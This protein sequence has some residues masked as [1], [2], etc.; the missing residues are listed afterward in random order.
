MAESKLKTQALNTGLV[1][2]SPTITTSILPTT[3]DGA[4][5][6]DL[7]HQF[8][9]LFLAEGGVINFD[10]GDATITQVGNVVTL[11]GADLVTDT[12]TVNT[13]LMPDA[14]DGA[15]LGQ[16]G[17]AFSDLFLAE[18]GIINWDSGDATLT[19]TGNT[20]ALGS[21][22]FNAS[23]VQFGYTTTTTAAGTLT[24][25]AASNRWQ[26]FTGSTTHTVTL[27]D[28]T[29]L[30]LGHQYEL[31]N[32][33][34]GSITVNSSGGNNVVTLAPSTSVVLTCILVT[35]TTAASW[36][37]IYKHFLPTN[38]T[39]LTTYGTT[40][41]GDIANFGAY[42][43]SW[44]PTFTNLTIGS[45]T[46]VSRYTQIGKK[47]DFRIALTFAADTSIAG[48]VAFTLPVT[49]ITGMIAREPI[50]M[51]TLYDSGTAVYEGMV[52][53]DLTNPTTKALIR[54]YNVAST[55][56]AIAAL[57]SL[58]PHGWAVNDAIY[59]YGTYEA[60]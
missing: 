25:D 4:P 5:L 34:T 40:G 50:G 59:L 30:V 33:S 32:K 54:T 36:D 27:P 38:N 21:A 17:T 13:G 52:I 57:S 2:T 10:G 44:T 45:G 26:F 35:G 31:R 6:G 22:V 28:V 20:V 41:G 48:D 55:Y 60:A 29:T 9:D 37:V 1:L 18:G 12:T 39:N 56:P 15:Y 47:I 23:N 46:L 43:T 58:I 42:T 49:G 53:L 16:A 8:S 24:L 11:A 3:N 19:Q 14:N 51:A 7:T